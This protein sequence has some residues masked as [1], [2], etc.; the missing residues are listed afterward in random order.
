M[1]SNREADKIA[2]ATTGHDE[3]CFQTFADMV[4]ETTGEEDN[5]ILIGMFQAETAVGFAG[6]RK[7]TCIEPVTGHYRRDAA[8]IAEALAA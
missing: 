5:E 4:V 8:E 3:G 6:E 2:A 1:I 7:C